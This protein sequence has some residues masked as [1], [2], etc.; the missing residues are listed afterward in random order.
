[1][2]TLDKWTCGV[3]FVCQYLASVDNLFVPVE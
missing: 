2:I 3:F 1:V